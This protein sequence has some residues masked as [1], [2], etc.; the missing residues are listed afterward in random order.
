MTDVVMP[1]LGGRELAERL[2]QIYPRMC[3]L[4]TSGYTDDA[5][6][7]HGV[8]EADTNFIQKPFTPGDLAHK[9][10]DILDGR[11]A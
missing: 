1:Q 6:V 11:E 5:I 8:I 3:I 4:F 10:R 7:R 9:I 2:A